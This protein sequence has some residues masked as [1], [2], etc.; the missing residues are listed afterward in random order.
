MFDNSKAHIDPKEH[1]IEKVLNELKI[2]IFL[3]SPNMTDSL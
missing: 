2:D 3:L 1:T